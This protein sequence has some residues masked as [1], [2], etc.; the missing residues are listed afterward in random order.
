M[1]TIPLLLSIIVLSGAS[2]FAQF[3]P[4]PPRQQQPAPVMQKGRQVLVDFR[5]NRAGRSAKISNATQRLVLSK[6]FRRY[7]T[8]QS[9]CNGDFARDETDYLAAA[10]RSGQIV[11]LVA[12]MVT[13]SFTAPGQTET[14]YV[15]F[16]NECNAS[17]ADNYGTKRVAIFAGQQLVADVD[18]DF[19]SSFVR[20]T[21]LNS[22]GVDELLMTAGDMNQGTVIEI[23]SLVEFRNGRRRVIEN[24]GTVIE[25]TCA[26]GSPGSSAKAVLISFSDIEPGKMPKLRIENYQS[27][28][29]NV[30]RWRLVGTG[31]MQ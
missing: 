5:Q 9:R 27:P 22:D 15:V 13:G 31:K 14:A 1:K 11:P 21:D 7:L 16:V 18:A 28:C 8:D 6:M 30:K 23:A 20:K 3:T 24:L 12:E 29:R 25:N 26:S 10:R 2:V 4:K 19:K 17:H